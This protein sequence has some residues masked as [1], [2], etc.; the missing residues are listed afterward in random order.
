M[1]GGGFLRLREKQYPSE[2]QEKWFSEHKTLHITNEAHTAL[3]KYAG[4][5]QLRN[6]EHVTI[7]MAIE[8][9]VKRIIEL[10]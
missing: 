1:K 4:K 9:V 6:G 5:M 10:D 2:K 8:E 7:S 3:L